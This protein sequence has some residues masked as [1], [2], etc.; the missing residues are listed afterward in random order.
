MWVLDENQSLLVNRLPDY[1]L[2]MTTK[3]VFVWENVKKVFHPQ[4]LY[5]PGRNIRNK[6]ILKYEG[7]LHI[8]R[9]QSI[10]ISRAQY[11]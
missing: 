4:H 7:Q 5:P 11:R 8:C 2:K 3:K 6:L 10:Y 1:F 9:H